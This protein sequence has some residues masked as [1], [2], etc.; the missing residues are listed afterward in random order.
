LSGRGGIR[1]PAFSA[2]DRISY[3]FFTVGLVGSFGATGVSGDDG[4]VVVGSTPG[5]LGNVGGVRGSMGSG[6]V[7]SIGLIWGA[8]LFPLLSS[9]VRFRVPDW[10]SFAPDDFC[11]ACDFFAGVFCVSAA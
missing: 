8:V 11:F 10:R 9:A 7:G 2:A 4:A 6:F 3:C 5:F 1:A